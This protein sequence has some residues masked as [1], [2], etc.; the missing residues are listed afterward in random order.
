MLPRYRAT[1]VSLIWPAD[2]PWAQPTNYTSEGE[3]YEVQAAWKFG[4]D[5]FPHDLLSGVSRDSIFGG[6]RDQII[7]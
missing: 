3:T 2:V 7:A 5:G 4:T 6:M 1:E